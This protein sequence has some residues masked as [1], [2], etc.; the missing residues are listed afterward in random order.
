LLD[1]LSEGV[2]PRRNGPPDL[3]NRDAVPLRGNAGW[4]RAR[5]HR[6]GLAPGYALA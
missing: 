1:R 4:A 3:P 5:R 6:P 2:P